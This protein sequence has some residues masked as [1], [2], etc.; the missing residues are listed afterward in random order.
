MLRDYSFPTCSANFGWQGTLLPLLLE[1]ALGRLGAHPGG[2]PP[3]H[4]WPHCRE[5]M[6]GQRAKIPHC[7]SSF[8]LF[9]AGARMPVILLLI[10]CVP[11]A[12]Q[13]SQTHTST[14]QQQGRWQLTIKLSVILAF[15]FFLNI[16]QKL[17]LQ[18]LL[19]GSIKEQQLAKLKYEGKKTWTN[20]KEKLF[21]SSH[22]FCNVSHSVLFSEWHSN[23]Q[24]IYVQTQRLVTQ[25][26]DWNSFS[27]SRRQ[28][29]LHMHWLFC[30]QRCTGPIS[31]S[32]SHEKLLVCIQHS[33]VL[34]LLC[35]SVKWSNYT[36]YSLSGTEKSKN[37]THIP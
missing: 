9:L 20:K 37:L 13:S 6:G 19:S 28:V 1:G 24:Q 12:T 32:F 34:I 26:L 36:D 5:Q 23:P 16:L 3:C 30:Q 31:F 10:S 33:L 25:K 29:A 27:A 8:C 11:V 4:P 22:W 18:F 7:D 15:F 17:L 2:L 14:S 35:S 21:K